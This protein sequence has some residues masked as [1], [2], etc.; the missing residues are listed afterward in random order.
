MTRARCIVGPNHHFRS[1]GTTRAWQGLV[2][3]VRRFGQ[4][5]R[6]RRVAA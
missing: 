6:N 1:H 5:S 4:T 2:N 3:N